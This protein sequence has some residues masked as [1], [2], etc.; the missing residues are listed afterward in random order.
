MI[1]FE[2]AAP[3]RIVFGSGS[4]DHVGIEAVP[5]G[6]RALIVCGR[7]AM[8][9]SGVLDRVRS[10]LQERGVSSWVYDDVSTDPKSREVDDAC[11]AARRYCVEVIIGLGGGSAL[12]AAKAAGVAVTYESVCEIIG[13]TLPSTPGALPVVAIPTTTGSGAEVTRGAIIT[14]VERAFKSGIRGPDIFPRVALVDPDLAQTMPAQV[15]AATAFDALTHAIEPYVARKANPLTDAL[16]ETALRLLGENVRS[17]ATGCVG[18]NERAAM[19]FAA[20]L[21]GL[22]VANAST[23]LPHRLQQAM[24]AAPH[25][26]LSHGRGLAGLYRVWIDHAYP[27]A[28]TKFDRIAYLL[29]EDSIHDAI[30]RI[31]DELDLAKPLRAGGLVEE[32][33][34]ACVAAV[35]GNVENDP[36]GQ[37]GPNLMRTIYSEA[38]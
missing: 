2:H 1:S 19:A 27:Y 9:S 37:I 32:D 34:D 17:V 36:I 29:G 13:K 26:S 8:R 28:H 7:R 5:L 38:L 24:G 11:E 12:D 22:T 6:S 16:C 25:V 31:L 21:G 18:P 14:D 10:S 23:C 3:T 30:A 35:S 33:I 15:A 20:L 4:V